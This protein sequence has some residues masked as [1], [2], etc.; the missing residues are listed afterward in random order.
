MLSLNSATTSSAA[1][2][3]ATLVGKFGKPA[4]T[5]KTLI[6]AAPISVAP[7]YEVFAIRYASVPD[8]PLST[9]SL[10]APTRNTNHLLP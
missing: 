5:K 10:P 8:I 7:V 6:F 3:R 1:T 4:Q 2:P 9:R